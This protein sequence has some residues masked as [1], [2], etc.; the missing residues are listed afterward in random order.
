MSSASSA[1]PDK[2]SATMLVGICFGASVLAIVLL[3]GCFICY[4]RRQLREEQRQSVE[5]MQ[6]AFDAAAETGNCSGARNA[7]AFHA[8]QEYGAKHG[9]YA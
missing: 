7:R 1:E 6:E 2:M 8:Y 9:S 5:A 3:L 4:K